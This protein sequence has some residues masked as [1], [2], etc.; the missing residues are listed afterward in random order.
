MEFA[1]FILALLGLVAFFFI[2]RHATKSNEKLLEMK[3]QTKLLRLIATKLGVE[4]AAI[5]SHIAQNENPF[6]LKWD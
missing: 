5:N 6:P 4:D 1:Y 2:I 3:R